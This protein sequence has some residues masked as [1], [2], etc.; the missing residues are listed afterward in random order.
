MG[1]QHTITTP[2]LQ[3][4]ILLEGVGERSVPHKEYIYTTP[5]LWS[6]TLLGG[7]GERSVPH[8]GKYIYLSV[9][10]RQVGICLPKF[11][12]FLTQ[13]TYLGYLSYLFDTNTQTH[14]DGHYTKA[15]LI[16][17][18]SGPRPPA[19]PSGHSITHTQSMCNVLT[20]TITK[21]HLQIA[22]GCG[23]AQHPPQGKIYTTPHLW[24][25]IILLGGVGEL[26]VQRPTQG[27][28]YLLVSK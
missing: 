17:L 20:Q 25:T 24:S 23:G 19:S 18:A 26:S 15:L 4:T 21:P 8:K 16:I 27:K 22:R 5:H 12:N 3:S 1:T 13:D 10:S 11:S 9:S 7:V 28:I 14:T 6:T 2:H